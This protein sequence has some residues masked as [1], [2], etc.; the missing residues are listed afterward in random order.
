MT[1]LIA[2]VED[3]RLAGIG[4]MV[5]AFAGFML[6]DVCAK[7][8]AGAGLPVAQIVFVR[9]AGHLALVVALFAPREGLDMARMRSP[10]LVTAR[11]LCLLGGT[12][13]NFVAVQSLPLSLTATVFFTA[14]LW[15]CALSVP[16]LG[17]QVGPRR[18]AAVAVGFLGVLIATR[19]W[20]AAVDW[21][22]GW[23]FASALCAALYGILTRRLAGVDGAATQQFYAAA[24][25]TVAVTPFAFTGWVWPVAPLD[26][27]AL[28][29][30][31]VFGWAGHQLLT[32][33]HRF[34][35]AS[36]LAPFT[37]VHLLFMSAAGWLVFGDAPDRWTLLGAAIT[38][39][40][41]LY[42]WDRERRLAAL[43]PA[44]KS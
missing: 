35:P 41:G 24:M 26:W 36:A 22:I 10:L 4:L 11:S 30:I 39:A 42:V 44:P 14:P 20:S 33:A 19:P 9:F 29:L 25:A 15:V 32:R 38:L 18:W 12:V 27:A 2:P 17:E 8:L 31:G 43:R 40:A 23:S 28:A 5:S 7:W 13:F 21:A 16:L 3:R 37:Y 34:A 1:A 6:I